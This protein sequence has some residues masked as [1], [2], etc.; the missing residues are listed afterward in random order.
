MTTFGIAKE[1]LPVFYKIP[2]VSHFQMNNRPNDILEPIKVNPLTPEWWE[3]WNN[4]SP[5]ER[6]YSI[7]R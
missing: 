6:L 1:K 2:P 3:I 7:R 4:M 5:I